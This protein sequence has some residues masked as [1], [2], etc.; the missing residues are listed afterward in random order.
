MSNTHELSSGFGTALRALSDRLED[1]LAAISCDSVTGR[2]QE[3]AADLRHLVK[4]VERETAN[5][6]SPFETEMRALRLENETLRAKGEL[7]ETLFENSND[8]IVITTKEGRFLAV[9]QGF[10]RLV[11]CRT[12]EEVFAR[13]IQDFYVEPRQ[14]SQ[15]RRKVDRS[16]VA[17]DFELKL[18]RID[19]TEFDTLHTINV[20]LDSSGRVSGYQGIMRDVTERKLARQALQEA[21]DELQVRVRERTAELAAT[22]AR[23]TSEISERARAQEALILSEQRMR[24]IFEAAT[25]CISIKNR[26]LK[27]TLVNPYMANLLELS[28]ADIVGKTDKEVFGPEAGRH[29]EELDRRVLMGETIEEEHTRPVKGL[30][31]TFLDVHSPIR[32]SSGDIIGVCGISRNITDRTRIC[33]ADPVPAEEYLSPAMRL[34]LAR[35]N[36][37]A[38]ADVIV[39]IEGESGAGKDYLAR[40]VHNNSKRSAGPF[41][42][43]NCAAI[44]EQLAESELFGHEAGAFTGAIR[45]KRGVFELA[46]GGSLLLNEIGELSLPIQAK[47]LTF[48]DTFSFTRVGGEKS[49]TVNVRIM[50]ATNRDLGQAVAKG[51]FRRDLFFRLNVYRIC[52]PPLRERAADI[53]VL[54]RQIV[55]R[56]AGE[57]LLGREMSIRSE[58]MEK[59]IRYS[60]PG[61]VRE[62][63]N[64]LERSVIISEGPDLRMDFLEST[65]SGESEAPLVVNFPPSPSLTSAVEGLRREFIALALDRT[66]G[67]QCAAARMLGISRYALK[68]HLTTL[69]MGGRDS[70]HNDSMCAVPPK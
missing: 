63:K 60:W 45:R 62:L 32:N 34:T 13:R 38:N 69:K 65:E 4:Q 68:R 46:E 20:R 40:Y 53:P 23:L 57:M 66:G 1:L 11:G 26:S 55:S 17:T 64:I 19:G 70:P 49:V 24:A 10:V 8:G 29:M 36:V 6:S 41:Y 27:Y 21:R 42:A 25:E 59:L 15:M 28:A 22:N 51:E 33:T 43:I 2:T 58:D 30:P 37:A 18:R 7:H 35:A 9:N 56:L 14:R 54:T 5:T 67:N 52:V 61:N 3:I 39:L 16:G 50:A 12:K 47:L 44:S 48:L 31:T